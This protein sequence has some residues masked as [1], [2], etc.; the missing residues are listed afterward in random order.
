MAFVDTL[1]EESDAEVVMIDRRHA[2][3]GHWLDAYPFVRLHQPSR[4]YGVNSTALGSESRMAGGPEAGLYERAGAA[5]ICAYYE[6]VMRE[7]LISSGQVRFFPQCDHTGEGR[8]V[9]RLTGETFEVEVRKRI[10]NAAYLPSAIPADT[11]PSFEVESGVSCVTPNQLVDLADHPAGYVVLGGGKT[12][13]D[14]CLWLLENGVD[15]D[16]IRWVKPREAWLL[17]RDYF[18]PDELVGDLLEGVTRQMEAAAGAS[19]VEDLF[20]RLEAAEQIR[21]VDPDVRPT[22]LKGA[23]A[24]E[25]EIELLRRIGNV[26]RLGRVRRIE[27]ERMLFDE[28]EVATGPG[29]LYVHCTAAGLARPPS[30]PIFAPE[31][32]TLQAIRFGLPPFAGAMIGFIEANRDDDEEKNRLCPPN[33]YTDTDLDWARATVIGMNADYAWSKQPD[34]AAWLAGARLNPGSGLAARSGNP[35]IQQAGRRLAE[36]TRP[37]LTRLAEL[38]G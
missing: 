16:A 22:M 14:V 30:L 7:R 2:P 26:D 35:Q 18:Q 32:I 4:Y 13:I 23:T 3:G 34:I 25:W 37:G 28:G 27:R 12:A 33:R 15:P 29:R 21:R 20:E 1:I 8:F 24:A 10:V 31:R 38:A 17:N 19:S 5:E 11:P 6:R 36:N 9:S